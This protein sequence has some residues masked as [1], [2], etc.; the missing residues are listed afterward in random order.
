MGLAKKQPLG[1]KKWLQHFE[2][3]LYLSCADIPPQ[4]VFAAVNP[5][6]KIEEFF[7]QIL[8]FLGN[9]THLI[10][11]VV[12]LGVKVAKLTRV[13]AHLY[14]YKMECYETNLEGQ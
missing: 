7:C 5:F 11:L 4:M 12:Y 1:Q 8:H 13:F 6:S 10:L 2:E 9:G 3:K 14:K